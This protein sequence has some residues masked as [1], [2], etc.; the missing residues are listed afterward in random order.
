MK[1]PHT[2]TKLDRVVDL[3]PAAASGLADPPSIPLREDEGIE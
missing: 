3:K 1:R 2:P